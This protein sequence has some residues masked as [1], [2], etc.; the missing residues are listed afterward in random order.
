MIQQKASKKP[1]PKNAEAGS[2]CEEQHKY[3]RKFDI[4]KTENLLYTQKNKKV[5]HHGIK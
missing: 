4:I 3:R 1:C 2:G 5:A